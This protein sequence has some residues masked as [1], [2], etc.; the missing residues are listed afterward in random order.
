[1][2]NQ[3]N[4]QTV[5][6]IEDFYGSVRSLYLSATHSGC[7]QNIINNIKEFENG[8]LSQK[9]EQLLGSGMNID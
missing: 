8:Q 1:M 3:L 4:Q 2:K 5:N 6:T 7:S 9:I